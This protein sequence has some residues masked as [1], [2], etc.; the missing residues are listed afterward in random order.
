MKPLSCISC[1]LD[2][3][4]EKQ[5]IAFVKIFCNVW[6]LSHLQLLLQYEDS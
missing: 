3:K 6:A 1:I 4:P 2:L 5:V